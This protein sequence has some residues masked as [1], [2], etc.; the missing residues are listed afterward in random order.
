MSI[1]AKDTSLYRYICIAFPILPSF[2][3]GARVS[4][5][6]DDQTHDHHFSKLTPSHQSSV[7]GFS[8]VKLIRA[9]HIKGF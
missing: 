7:A 5:P 1:Q 6:H 4:D 2:I 3:H 9:Y 8:P